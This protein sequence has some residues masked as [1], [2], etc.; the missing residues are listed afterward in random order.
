MKKLSN[1]K[2]IKEYL[3]GIVIEKYEDIKD[4]CVDNQQDVLLIELLL[5]VLYS[6]YINITELKV[7][8]GSIQV[9]LCKCNDIEKNCLIQLNGDNLITRKKMDKVVNGKIKSD[10]QNNKDIYSYILLPFD[11]NKGSLNT[12]RA[13]CVGYNDNLFVFFESLGELYKKGFVCDETEDK[14]KNCIC[15]YKY[16]WELFGEGEAGYNHYIDAFCLK[17]IHGLKKDYGEFYVKRIYSKGWRNDNSC[18]RKKIYNN[19]ENLLKDFHG[20]RKELMINRLQE[21]CTLAV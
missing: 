20:K 3:Y 12:K 11:S 10:C 18:R 16:F 1:E 17:D 15:G 13:S 8:S 19:Y 2:T 14:V 9:R 4:D 5:F 6:G 7:V 21:I